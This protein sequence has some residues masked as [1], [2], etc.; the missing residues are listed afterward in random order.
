LQY[1]RRKRA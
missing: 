1:H